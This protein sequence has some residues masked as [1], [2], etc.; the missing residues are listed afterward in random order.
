MVE[1]VIGKTSVRHQP[2]VNVIKY[3]VHDHA[4]SP[5]MQCIYHVLQ[6]EKPVQR[7]SR[8]FDVAVLDAKEKIRIITPVEIIA[9]PGRPRHELH[10]IDAKVDE[11]VELVEYSVHRRTV[12]T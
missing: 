9:A 5:A 12:A 11:I 10:R 3:S 4:D 6:P 7:V 8:V 1:P 2:G